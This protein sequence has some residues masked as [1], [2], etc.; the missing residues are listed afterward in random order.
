MPSARA[1]V[2]YGAS[3]CERNDSL[4]KRDSAAATG[5]ARHRAG[6][7]RYCTARSGLVVKPCGGVPPAG[8]TRTTTASSTISSVP[9]TNVGN[10]T[11]M[12]LKPD[13]T[14][15][16][17]RRSASTPPTAASRARSTAMT[18]AAAVSTTVFVSPSPTSVLMSTPTT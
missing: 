5:R 7:R 15:S 11:A 10:A 3:I 16:S 8:S 4:R 2:T 1:V 17:Q 18:S 6:I 9:V 12:V 14:E 13:S